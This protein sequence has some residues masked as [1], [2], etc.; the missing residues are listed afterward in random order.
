M[1]LKEIAQ[2]ISRMIRTDSNIGCLESFNGSSIQPFNS[3]YMNVAIEIIKDTLKSNDFEG[4]NLSGISMYRE[5]P[6]KV[7]YNKTNYVESDRFYSLVKPLIDKYNSHLESIETIKKTYSEIG[8]LTNQIKAIKSLGQE[9]KEEDTNEKRRDK[10]LGVL[11]EKIKEYASEIKGLKK[12]LS[13]F[14]ENQS[15]VI[16]QDNNNLDKAFKL[17]DSE[18]LPKY[19]TNKAMTFCK[20]ANQSDIQKFLFTQQEPENSVGTI[21]L[22]SGQ[23]YQ[24]VY[25]FD[26]S[27]IAVKEKEGYKTPKMDIAAYRE[28]AREICE[29][30]V[31]FMLRKKHR[32]VSPML[33]KMKEENYNLP[34]AVEAIQSIINNENILKNFEFDVIKEIKECKKLE[35]FDDKISALKQKHEVQ[36][37][38]LSII[39][40]KYKHLYTED[41]YKTF[42]EIYDLKVSKEHLQ[43]NIGKKIASFKTPEAFKEALEKYK[44]SLS[45]FNAFNI[46]LKTDNS[47]IEKVVDSEDLII[48]KINDF[49][50]SNKLGSTSWCISRSRTYFN[51]YVED[52]KEHMQFFVYDF[53]KDSKEDESM[54]GITLKTNGSYYA[55]HVKNDDALRETSSLFKTYRNQIIE[56]SPHLFP[57]LDQDLAKELGLNVKQK[58]KNAM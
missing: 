52:N 42:K 50:A 34:V 9:I 23:K 28:L 36:S 38:A 16:I 55:A 12:N 1:E 46:R 15:P 4:R 41:C 22:T 45:E 26:D 24:E 32:L 10:R 3:A 53:T 14:V 29:E 40:S 51:S 25:L 18:S 27:S 39:S 57:E 35:R 5:D 8:S 17:M 44:R 2:K 58:L 56:S 20:M 30:T 11:N 7:Y 33:E 31:K 47:D 37:F 43:D 54:I 19:K 13:D 49:E 21:K 6:L 48:L